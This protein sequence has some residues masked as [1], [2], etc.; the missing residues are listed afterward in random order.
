V[1]PSLPNRR[2]HVE[3]DDL[4]RHQV[5]ERLHPLDVVGR[6]AQIDRHRLLYVFAPGRN[7]SQLVAASTLGL[8][9]RPRAAVRLPFTPPN[10]VGGIDA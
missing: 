10:V 7:R 4:L 3:I 6:N 1:L 2:A 8:T 9:Q 5:V